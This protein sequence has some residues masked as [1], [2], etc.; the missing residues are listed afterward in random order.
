M[1]PSW[2]PDVRAFLPFACCVQRERDLLR[3]TGVRAEAW[4]CATDVRSTPTSGHS[5]ARPPM[6]VKCQQRTYGNQVLVLLGPSDKTLG[7]MM[8]TH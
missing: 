8:P 4:T 3:R 1:V 7:E 5:T 6:S 2:Y